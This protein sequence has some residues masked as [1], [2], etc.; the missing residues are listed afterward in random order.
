MGI[1]LRMIVAIKPF[2]FQVIILVLT[3]Y[4]FIHTDTDTRLMILTD[5]DTRVMILNDTDIRL[6]ILIDTDTSLLILTDTDT[7]LMIILILI[8]G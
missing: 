8:P 3:R 6:M 4:A 1:W 7:R 5:T 2:Y